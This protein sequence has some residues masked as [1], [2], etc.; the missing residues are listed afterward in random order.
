MSNFL[1]DFVHPTL[2]DLISGGVRCRRLRFAPPTVN[3]V[4]PLRG[5]SS[6][7]LHI[8]APLVAKAITYTSLPYSLIVY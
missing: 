2:R 3:K 8:K 5:F 6:D 7:N 4:S 1:S